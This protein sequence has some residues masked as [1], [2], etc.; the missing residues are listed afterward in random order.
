MVV[1]LALRVPEQSML[2][3]VTF[4]FAL[5]QM[6][7]SASVMLWLFAEDAIVSPS[8]WTLLPTDW[9]DSVVTFFAQWVAKSTTLFFAFWAF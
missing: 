7:G 3:T 5:L 8:L 6:A 2:L 9:T 1:W 4:A